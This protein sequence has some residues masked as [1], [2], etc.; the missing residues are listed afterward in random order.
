M[1]Q[2]STRR[3]F[4]G[5]ASAA[6]A[7]P[8]RSVGASA[9]P[10]A[11]A[12]GVYFRTGD[13]N[14]GQSNGGFIVCDDYAIA[15]DA[16]TPEAAQEMLAEAQS[17]S[18]KPL[19]LLILT[20]AHGDHSKGADALIAKGATVVCHDEL[21]R[22]A[23]ANRTRG[24]LMGV[25][26]K[27]T[28]GDS[29]QPVEVFTAGTAHSPTDLFVFLPNH[30]VLFT[31]D[32]VVNMPAMYMG[33]CNLD[34]WIRTLRALRRRNIKTVCP[35]HG[36][37]GGPE[38][39]DN[40]ANH[41]TTLRD[42]IGYQIA[43]GRSFEAAVDQIKVP[44]WVRWARDKKFFDSQVKVVYGQ[45]T[46]S[47]PAPPPAATPHALVLIG[48]F[49]H[50]PGWSRPPL[51]AVFEKIGMP[52]TFLYD[53]TRLSAASL[54]G[55]RLLVILRDGMNRPVVNGQPTWWMTPEQ[56][57]AIVEFVANGGGYLALHNAT[58]LKEKPAEPSPY[59]EMLGSSY[60]GHGPADEKFQVRV[61]NKDHPIT[62]GV[63]DYDSV[64]EH[65]RP[66]IHA[67]DIV[68]LTETSTKKVNGYIRTHGQGRV[69]Y[70]ATGHHRAMLELPSM[71]QLLANAARWCIGS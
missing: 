15:I 34:N 4:L 64:D 14:R 63:S 67:N 53:V 40:V 28:L 21:R 71:Q 1:R 48:D 24:V 57:R 3:D 45:L 44:E 33:E 27:L 54:Q 50:R 65:H 18:R 8:A 42:E 60:N 6:C 2:N 20:H 38:L 11:V 46:A 43:Q 52:A 9:A 30:G 17:I 51:E 66:I 68:L 22:Q 41:L 47:V 5:A 7:L 62:R 55:Y 59:R 61:V 12:P 56:E 39:I 13:L 69:C 31:G 35:G 37:A 25:T 32:A 16:P 36:P 26:G 49:Y 19:L 29:G 70:L 58:A 23:L 10:P